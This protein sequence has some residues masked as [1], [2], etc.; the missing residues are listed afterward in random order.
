MQRRRGFGLDANNFDAIRIPG[1]DAADQSTTTDSDQERVEIGGLLLELKPD[2]AL[3][4]QRLELIVGM[5][6]ERAR[7]G[8]PMFTR[9]ER[10]RVPFADHDEFRTIA[11]NAFDLFSRSDRGHKDLCW[12]AECHRGKGNRCAVVSAGRCNYTGLRNSSQKQVSECST[13][14]EGSRVLEQLK[15]ED[16]WDGIQAELGAIRSNH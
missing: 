10:F 12:N 2:G 9:S 16:E 1:R 4:E 13:R 11:A 15:F 3:T 7:L 5:H 8:G 6:R 14:F